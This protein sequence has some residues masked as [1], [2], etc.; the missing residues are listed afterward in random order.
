MWETAFLVLY[1]SSRNNSLPIR[2]RPLP[3]GPW[4]DVEVN[5]KGPIGGSG[6]FYY[7]VVMD[8]FIWYPEV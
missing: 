5:Y 4:K 3:E 8:M 1:L 7:H 6:G 2:N